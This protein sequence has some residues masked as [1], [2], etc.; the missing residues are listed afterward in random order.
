M[1]ELMNEGAGQRVTNLDHQLNRR[2]KV[3]R[4]RYNS[5][6]TILGSIQDRTGRGLS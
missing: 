2:P 3:K 5:A 1:N 4:T 6:R